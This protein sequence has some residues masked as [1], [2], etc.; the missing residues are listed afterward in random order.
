[1]ATPEN[2]R[3]DFLL[4]ITHIRQ[5]FLKV[6]GNVGRNGIFTFPDVHKLSE[7]LFI[8]ALTYWEAVCRDLLILEL[9]TDTSGILKKEISKFRTK[10]AA[11]R[12]AEKILSHPDHPEKFIE[13]SSFSA[14]ESRANIFLGANH[15]FK[16]TQATNDDIAKL[17]RIRNAIA[18]KSDKAWGSFIKLISASPFGVTSSQRK[19]IT[20][21]RF[22]YSNQWNG[23]TVMERT[24][25]LLE[26]AVRELVP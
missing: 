8:S 4:S 2:I 15:R 1:M 3:D 22:I 6:S 21:G 10:G 17:K 18:H 19:G 9:A 26:N 12:L 16:L 23:N 11:L 13:W 25:I 14:I 7:G 24:L 20:P 5:A